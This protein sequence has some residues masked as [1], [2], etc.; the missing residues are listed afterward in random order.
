MMLD[1]LYNV[2]GEI[3]LPKAI[4]YTI[5]LSVLFLTLISLGINFLDWLVNIYTYTRLGWFQLGYPDYEET[6]I[7]VRYE[8]YVVGFPSGEIFYVDRSKLRKLKRKKL[9]KWSNAVGC[10]CYDDNDVETIKKAIKPI[11]I[12]ESTRSSTYYDVT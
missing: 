10:Y 12:Y 5:S 2:I 11:I 8:I 3:T 1:W 7:K 9:I 4:I 6:I